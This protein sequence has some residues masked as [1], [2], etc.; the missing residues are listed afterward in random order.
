M[1]LGPFFFWWSYL[2]KR[3]VV[4]VIF[5]LFRTDV[6]KRSS[7]FTTF[8][9][10]G[11]DVDNLFVLNVATDHK[12]VITERVLFGYRAKTRPKPPE[13]KYIIFRNLESLQVLRSSPSTIYRPNY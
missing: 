5:A 1:K 10:T 3:N 6:W 4:P 2:V 12:V 7:S 8:D 11:A 9:W 13:K